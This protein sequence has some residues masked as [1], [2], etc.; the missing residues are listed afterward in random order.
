[1]PAAKKKEV[2]KTFRKVSKNPVK[3]E[4][5]KNPEVQQL[6]EELFK[7]KVVDTTEHEVVAITPQPSSSKVEESVSQKD[8][9]KESQ[10]QETEEELLA[11]ES[12]LKESEGGEEEGEEKDDEKKESETSEEGKEGLEQEGNEIKKEEKSSKKSL[13]VLGII[14][15]F[16]GA[17]LGIFIF[18]SLQFFGTT[19]VPEREE[20]V[21]IPAE[22]PTATPEPELSFEN[23]QLQVLNGSGVSGQA[24]QNAQLLEDKLGFS[25]EN[26]DTGNAT[27]EVEDTTVQ[28]KADVPEEVY[29]KIKEVLSGFSF[30]LGDPLASDSN[31]DIVITL[32]QQQ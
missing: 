24:A 10:V 18:S 32:G 26:V 17:I 16:I 14:F 25:S 27:D 7:E 4:K 28:L 11:A 19:I 31:Y 1:M 29:E 5:A 9:P 30:S 3:K 6:R 2:K 20:V 15:L 12:K 13:L 23:Y 8:A 22:E 21:P